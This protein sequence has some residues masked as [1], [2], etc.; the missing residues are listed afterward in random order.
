LKFVGKNFE[1]D[2]VDCVDDFWESAETEGVFIQVSISEFGKNGCERMDVDWTVVQTPTTPQGTGRE[3]LKREIQAR[4]KSA[5]E[6][7]GANSPNG[8]LISAR[9]GEIYSFD[10]DKLYHTVDVYHMYHRNRTA[11]NTGTDTREV[12]TLAVEADKTALFATV[13]ELV[14]KIADLQ[15]ICEYV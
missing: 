5:Y 7:H 10:A 11:Q 9:R 1:N 13:K 15:G 12:I 2:T 14:N 4:E 8:N 6:Y 3:L